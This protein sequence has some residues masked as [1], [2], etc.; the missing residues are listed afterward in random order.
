MHDSKK[1]KN[2][3]TS[4][5]VICTATYRCVEKTQTHNAVPFQ[6]F[7]EEMCINV[8]TKAHIASSAQHTQRHANGA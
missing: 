2:N 7:H 5:C 1:K 6:H 8:I 3:L 4:L